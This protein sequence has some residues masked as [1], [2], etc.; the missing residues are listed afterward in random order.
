LTGAPV[1]HRR[2][3]VAAAAASAKKGEDVVALDV[4][5]ILSITDAF[6][7][8]SATNTR[9]VRTIVEEIER[10]MK[11]HASVPP[12]SVEGL[13]DAT[14]VLLDYGDVVVHVFLD[15]TRAYYELERL[16]ADAPRVEW[17]QLVPASQTASA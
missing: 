12:T 2:V 15:E 4:G 10:A 1:V 13:D 17:E 16:W 5:D 6:V 11:E 9:H 3:A 8:T 14:W 7:I